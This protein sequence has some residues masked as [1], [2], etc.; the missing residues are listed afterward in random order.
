MQDLA[1]ELKES[2]FAPGTSEAERLKVDIVRGRHIELSGGHFKNPVV[3]WLQ[4]KGF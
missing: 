1:K 4:A 3:Q 2:L